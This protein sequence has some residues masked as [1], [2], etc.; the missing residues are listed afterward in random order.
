MS[1]E[2]EEIH[3]GDVGTSLE[4]EVVEQGQ[5]LDI[6]A[7]TN[8]VMRFQK[9]SGTTV[10]QTASFVTDGSDGLLRYVTQ[11][12]DLD[13]SGWWTRQARFTLGGWSGSS[14]RV[15]FRVWPILP[16]P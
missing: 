2:R 13:E 3:E 4:L 8:L 14:S 9:P 10:D 11:A 1:V 5:A 7:A 6:G 16:A 15:R 12:G